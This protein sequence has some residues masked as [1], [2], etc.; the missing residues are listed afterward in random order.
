[1]VPFGVTRHGWISVPSFRKCKKKTAQIQGAAKLCKAFWSFWGVSPLITQLAWEGRLQKP[2]SLTGGPTKQSQAET[3]KAPKPRAKKWR[4]WKK[5]AF[6]LF[7]HLMRLFQFVSCFYMVQLQQLFSLHW[8]Q[9]V[10]SPVTRTWC[11]F[12]PSLLRLMSSK[13]S[14]TGKAISSL[15]FNVCNNRQLS[16]SHASHQ[17]RTL[18]KALLGFS[19]QLKACCLEAFGTTDSERKLYAILWPALIRRS[20][21]SWSEYFFQGQARW[22][23]GIRNGICCRFNIC[24]QSSL[25]CGFPLSLNIDLRAKRRQHIGY[26]F[27]IIYLLV[28]FFAAGTFKPGADSSRA[29]FW[30]CAFILQCSFV[31]EAGRHVLILVKT[32]AFPVYSCWSMH[33]RIHGASMGNFD[34]FVQL[35]SKTAKHLG[36][37]W[38]SKRPSVPRSYTTMDKFGDVKHIYAPPKANQLHGRQEILCTL[39]IFVN[40]RRCFVFHVHLALNRTCGWVLLLPRFVKGI[41]WPDYGRKPKWQL[42][43][44]VLSCAISYRELWGPKL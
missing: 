13:C 27:T 23:F 9:D 41:W 37:F 28:H 39:L 5:S 40:V 21:H 20:L 1:M 11:Y 26:V 35:W 38:L 12:G 19:F 8:S 43:S 6:V 15:N 31:C 44:C 33:R 25:A 34:C 7:E 2:I 42:C 29:H 16:S 14:C 3:P 10:W 22:M 30:Y 18:K 4:Q 32:T 36:E 24:L 17:L